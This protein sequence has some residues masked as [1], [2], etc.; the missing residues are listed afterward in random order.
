[1][2]SDLV[3]ALWR[4]TPQVDVNGAPLFPGESVREI[5]AAEAETSDN[6]EPLTAAKAKK[7]ESAEKDAD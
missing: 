3:K 5:P 1:M 4:G 7:A 6:W 2:A